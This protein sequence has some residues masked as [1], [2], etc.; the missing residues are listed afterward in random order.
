MCSGTQHRRQAVDDLESLR[1][2]HVHLAG[3][4]I[5]RIDPRRLPDDGGA[6]HARA[7]PGVDVARIDR[8]GRSERVTGG[9]IDRLL[10]A[11]LI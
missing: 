3:H 11:E 1:V 6:E 2:D 8:R 10:G 4:Q 9:R 7:H 5:G